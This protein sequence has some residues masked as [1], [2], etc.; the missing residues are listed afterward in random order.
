MFR[1]V[2]GLKTDIKEVEVGRCMR[3]SDGKLCFSE[4]KRGKVMKDYI[5]RI[6]NE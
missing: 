1:L 2:K 5:E 3:A 4:M 6:M